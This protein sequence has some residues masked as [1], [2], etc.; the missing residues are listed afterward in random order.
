MLS[1]A[2]SA[3]ADQTSFRDVVEFI[4]A[5]TASVVVFF[6]KSWVTKLVDAVRDDVGGVKGDVADIRTDIATL[7]GRVDS[8]PNAVNVQIH[9][10]MNGTKDRLTR[11]EATCAMRHAERKAELNETLADQAHRA[12]ISPPGGVPAYREPN[13]MGS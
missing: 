9:Q 1:Q 10:V 7:S 4:A 2:T 3:I 8:I 6:S 11:L 12:Q 5:V 13:E